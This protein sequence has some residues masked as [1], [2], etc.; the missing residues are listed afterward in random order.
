MSLN[1]NALFY[2]KLLDYIS[3]SVCLFFFVAANVLH[4]RHLENLKSPSVVIEPQKPHFTYYLSYQDL[5]SSQTHMLF[6]NYFEPD[7]LFSVFK[8]INTENFVLINCFQNETNRLKNF[9]IDHFENATFSEKSCDIKQSD[10]EFLIKQ[11]K[12]LI[13]FLTRDFYFSHPLALRAAERTKLKP[14][15]QLSEVKNAN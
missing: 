4:F 9:L 1:N 11:E 7:F 10:L 12:T 5:N 6:L 8:H 13:I 15:I 14:K 2:K 3:V